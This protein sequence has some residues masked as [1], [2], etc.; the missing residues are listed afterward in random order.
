M[1]SIMSDWSIDDKKYDVLYQL[2][3]H[4]DHLDAISKPATSEEVF[5]DIMSGA[6]IWRDETN[7]DTPIAVIWALRTVVA[8]RT[9]LILNEPRTELKPYWESAQSL[10]ANWVGFLPERRKPTPEL[11]QVLRRGEVSLKKCLRDMEREP[12]K[13]DF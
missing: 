9:S 12:D 10:F 7:Q 1:A 5:Y 11:L 13:W 2:E 4:A 8:Y 3:E 6:L